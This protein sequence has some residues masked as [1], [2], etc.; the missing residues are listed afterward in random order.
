[1]TITT[2]LKGG[3]GNQLF[4][5]AF[6]KAIS[7]NNSQP[8]AINCHWYSNTPSHLT[9]RTLLLEHLRIDSPKI[10]DSAWPPLFS[11]L[12]FLLSLLPFSPVIFD[13]NPNSFDIKLFDRKFPSNRH[14]AFVGY[15][16]SFKY[17]AYIRPLLLEEFQAKKPINEYYSKYSAAITAT[18]SVMIHIRRSDFVNLKSAKNLHGALALS[19]Y[20]NAIGMIHEQIHSPHF[21]IFSDDIAWAQANLPQELPATFIHSD[22]SEDAVIQELQLMRLCKHH[23][24]ANSSLSWWGAWLS[25]QNNESIKICPDRWLKGKEINLDDLLPSNWTRLAATLL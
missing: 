10:I 1:M 11:A 6:A 5:Y 8:L 7:I 9:P 20:L 24:I 15:W 22:T 18:A 4:Q 3:L 21:F 12:N 2:Q 25:T 16:Q 13:R 14:F 23:I 19:Y 17:F